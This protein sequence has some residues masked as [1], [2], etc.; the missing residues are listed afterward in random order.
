MVVFS[1]ALA[2]N[3]DKNG[4]SGWPVAIIMLLVAV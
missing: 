4:F 1:L 3:F 2:I